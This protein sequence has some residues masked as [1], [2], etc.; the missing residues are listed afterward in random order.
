MGNRVAIPGHA[1][2]NYG[3]REMDEILPQKYNQT[4][5]I[6]TMSITWAWDQLPVY[7]ADDSAVLTLPANSRINSATIRTLEGFVGGES[8]DIGLYGPDGS[9]LYVDGIAALVLTATMNTV[10]ETV[11]CSGD[12]IGNTDGIGTDIG[13]VVISDNIGAT[14]FS[15]GRAVLEI[16]YTTLDDRANSNH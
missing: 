16:E 13:Q 15:A 11:V 1:Y 14:P 7:S 5:G 8:Y 9:V 3:T 2:T 6:K 12:L 10:G 4:G